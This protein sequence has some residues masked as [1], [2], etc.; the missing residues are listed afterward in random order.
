MNI[1]SSLVDRDAET[2][3]SSTK[4]W[5]VVLVASLFFFYEFIQMNMFNTI[6]DTLIDVFSL[7]GLQL[8]ILSSTY[9]ISNV[10][11]LFVA[12]ILLDRCATR[13]IILLALA[14]CVFGTATFSF[15]TS[16]EGAALSR[17]L[18]GIGSA[19]C[20]LSVIRLA[21]RW[22]PP[23]HMALV[24][25]VVITVAM[26]GGMV[27]QTPLT[28]LVNSVGWRH[29]LLL[30][31]AFGGVIFLLIAMI[32]QDYP[33]DHAKVHELELKVIHEIGYWKSLRMAFLRI[34]NWLG[35]IYT[36]CMNLPINVLGGLWGV[37]YVTKT[38]GI[39]KVYASSITM[40]LFLGAI[41]G[42]PL[43]GWISDSMGRRKPVMIIGALV[44]LGVVLILVCDARLS[45]VAC[46]LLFLLLGI[47]SGAQVIGYPLVAEGSR[48]VVTAMSVSVVN[49]TTIAGIGLIQSLFGRI[50]D[51]EV[52]HRL[53]HFSSNFIA[54]DFSWAM[55]LFPLGNIIALIAACIVKETYCHQR[56]K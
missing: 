43:A 34:Q 9:F 29:A 10:V 50:V 51:I 14:I 12:G 54:A 6:S 19:F 13:N 8:G 7:T 16:F 41:I 15:S 49:I 2:L 39:S 31:A 20:F 42:C 46:I 22:F 3:H 36:S 40:M 52:T 47:V 5:V 33:K 35:G 56:I 37:L 17:F 25:G 48:R 23:R 21:T 44:A 1:D 18:T 38:Y 26:I 45:F 55:W 4:A 53:H 28:L 32:V 27:S 30:D 11:F 24:T